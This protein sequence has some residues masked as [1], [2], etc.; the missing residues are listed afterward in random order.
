VWFPSARG[1]RVQYWATWQVTFWLAPE[2]A[3]NPDLEDLYANGKS[4]PLIGQLDKMPLAVQQ[5]TYR[6]AMDRLIAGSGTT[7]TAERLRAF[8]GVLRGGR[9]DDVRGTVIKAARTQFETVQDRIYSNAFVR[10]NGVEEF[11]TRFNQGRRIEPILVSPMA[12]VRSAPYFRT[13]LPWA[14]LAA[15]VVLIGGLALVRARVLAVVG[16]LTLLVTASVFGFFLMD[17][18]RFII[19]PLL[20]VLATATGVADEGWLHLRARAKR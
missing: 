8:L 7:W 10:D 5:A 3:S 15:I 20:F 16:L 12:P 9:N 1:E 17:N 18:V 11:L 4:F 6:V 13:L 14:I 19:V 2:N